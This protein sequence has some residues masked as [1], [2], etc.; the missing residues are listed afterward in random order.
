[1]KREVESVPWNSVQVVPSITFTS[2][3]SSAAP[4]ISGVEFN[5]LEAQIN[6]PLITRADKSINNSNPG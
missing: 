3:S 5:V 4:Q 1:M 6:K 2:L